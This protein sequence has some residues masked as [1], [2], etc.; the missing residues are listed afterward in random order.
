[1]PKRP[2]RHVLLGINDQETAVSVSLAPPSPTELLSSSFPAGFDLCRELW[3]Y[4][5]SR[6]NAW[7][8]EVPGSPAAA[9]SPSWQQT[10]LRNKNSTLALWE[11]LEYTFC[12][13]ECSR[14]HFLLALYSYFTVWCSVTFTSQTTCIMSLNI[15]PPSWD[16]S[17]TIYLLFS[18]RTDKKPRAAPL[19]STISRF[20]TLQL[21][22]TS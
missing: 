8:C 1:M 13:G 16:I 17:V 18:Q 2:K 10:P 22:R 6:S 5:A 3:V 11:M 9:S 15:N 21:Q 14:P 4:S 20:L 19:H 12:R 7:H